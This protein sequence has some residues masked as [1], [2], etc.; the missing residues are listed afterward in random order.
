[1]DNLQKLHWEKVYETKK[2]NEVSWTQPVPKT[3]LNF[4]HSYQLPKTASIIDV[5]GGDSNLVDHLLDEGFTNLTILDISTKALDNAK[6]RLGER[7]KKVNWIVSDIT[8]FEPATTYDLWHD[9][10]AFHFLTTK[11]Q[12]EK[13]ITIAERAVKKYMILATFSE[14]GPKKCSGL[15]V[16]QYNEETLELMLNNGFV[17][18][19]CVTEDHITPFNTAQNFLF[20][21]FKKRS[22]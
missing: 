6:Q 15:D 19:K 18:L 5:G 8:S 13:Y 21:S 16:Q 22:M 1:M 12:V 14:T 17:K 20:C 4:I 11:E 9:R 7:A 3:S 10:A 2:P